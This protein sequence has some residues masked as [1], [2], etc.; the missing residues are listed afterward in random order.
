MEGISRRDFLTGGLATLGVVF[1]SYRS[2][3]EVNEAWR[4]IREWDEK[5]V[6]KY[7]S[8]IE[9]IYDFKRNGNSKQKMARI[10]RIFSDDE[11]NL[12]NQENFLEN[13]NPQLSEHDLNLLNSQNHCGS[14]PKLLFNYYS[15]RRGLPASTTKIKMEKGLRFVSER[16]MGGTSLNPKDNPI[17]P[18]FGLIEFRLKNLV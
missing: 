13:G 3:A 4:H 8:W 9:N 6:V 12:L 2:G 1:Y 11:M 5:E 18:P 17:K 15:Y 7:S 16:Q 14:F 10:N